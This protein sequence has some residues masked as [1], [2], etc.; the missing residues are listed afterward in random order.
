MM[1]HSKIARPIVVYNVWWHAIC[2]HSCANT[3]GINSSGNVSNNPEVITINGFVSPYVYA[4]G[5]T[6]NS[7]KAQ[8]QSIS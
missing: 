3:V 5:F 4:L 2:P 1:L 6:S 7:T 8:E